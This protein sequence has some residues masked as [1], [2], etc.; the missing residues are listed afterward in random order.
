MR[1]VTWKT[2]MVVLFALSGWLIAG[3]IYSM[4]Y[5]TEQNRGWW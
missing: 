1:K 5:I 2:V 4:W 3:A